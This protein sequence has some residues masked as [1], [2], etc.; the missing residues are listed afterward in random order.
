L[1][2]SFQ[3]ATQLQTLIDAAKRADEV[4]LDGAFCMGN[5]IFGVSV[6]VDGVCHLVQPE[7]TKNFFE[8]EIMGKHGSF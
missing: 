7:K 2:G 6:A 3:I 4:E 5:C 8:K 1:K